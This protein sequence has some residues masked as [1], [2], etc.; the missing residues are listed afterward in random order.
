MDGAHAQNNQNWK[1]TRWYYIKSA[2]HIE[3]KIKILLQTK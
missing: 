2:T 1:S 3:K